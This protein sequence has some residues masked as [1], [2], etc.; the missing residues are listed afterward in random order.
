MSYH[1]GFLIESMVSILL[2]LTILYCV[3]LNKQLRLLKADEQTLRATISEL[4]TA[5]E[6]AERAIAGLK[7]TMREGEQSLGERLQR[8]ETLTADIERQLAA[9]EDLL[10]RL[11]RIAGAAPA[12]ERAGRRARRQGGRRRRASLRRTRAMRGSRGARRMIRFA[13]DF[14]LIPIVLLATIC[15]FALKVSGLVFDGGYTLAERLQGRDK[16]GMQI[17]TRES[18]PDYPKIVVADGQSL[19]GAPA[20]RKQSWAQEMFNF[21]GDRRHHRLGRQAARS[22]RPARRSRPSAKPPEPPKLEDRQR[23][24]AARGRA[25]SLRPASAPS[26]SACRTA[27]RSSTSRSRELD[28]RES[29]LKATEKRLDAKVTEL[30]DAGSARQQPPMGNRD[31]AEAERFKSIV[32]MYENMK[33]KDA[34]RIFDR[35]DMKILVEVTTQIKPRKM[36]EILAQMTP[37]AAERLTVELASRADA[38]PQSADQ[39]PKI[40]G[41]PPGSRGVM[42]ARR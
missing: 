12:A 37:E 19:A 40:E 41:K 3:R 32:S 21:G 25:R 23:H 29:L 15:L 33:S 20:S 8:A 35:L 9:G 38:K 28:M 14:R 27:A 1:Y 36:S 31:K 26:S 10:A 7:A 2:L 17:T 5:T 30:K 34:A 11:T 13:R 22:R 6:I 16:T 39:L 24:G 4:I 42:R 18:V